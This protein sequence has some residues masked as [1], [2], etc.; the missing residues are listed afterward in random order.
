M[1]DELLLG[2]TRAAVLREIYANP[3]RRVSFNE[4][5]RRL[6]SGPGALSRELVTLTTA[7]LILEQREGNQ[8]LI[9]ACLTSPVYA[10]LKAFIVKASGAP[11]LIREALHGLEDGIELAVVFG[12]VAA[13]VERSDSDLDLFVVGTAGYSVVTQRMYPLEDRLGRRVQ[14]LYF[15]A[16]SAI[17]RASLSKPSTRSMLAGRK[18][19]VLGD[20]ATLEALLSTQ[21][22]LNHGQ[23]SQSRQPRKGTKAGAARR[24]T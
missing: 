17:D 2:K 23:K 16:T 21:G 19:F 24:R 12:S 10:E 6:R 4:L 18:L 20:E 1:L 14:V 8:R 15:D 9:S 22:K 7:G 5:V 3:G 13:G 11:A